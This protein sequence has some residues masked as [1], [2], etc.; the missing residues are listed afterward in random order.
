MKFVRQC[1]TYIQ[2]GKEAC[3]AKAVDEEVLEDAFIRV[4]NQLYE[5][6]Y[7]FIKTLAEN[8]EKVLLQ[9]PSN[10]VIEALDDSIE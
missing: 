3:A 2:K 5:N 9:K 6:R 8:I 7:G 4:F 1:K 10:K